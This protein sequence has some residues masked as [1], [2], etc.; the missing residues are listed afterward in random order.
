MRRIFFT[1]LI[2]VNLL[3]CLVGISHASD[4][5]IPITFSV[6]NTAIDL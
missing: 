4:R 1:L 6:T 5:T 2:A 3:G